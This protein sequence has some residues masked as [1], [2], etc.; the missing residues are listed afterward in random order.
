MSNY[1]Q[2]KEKESENTKD[3]STKQLV[4]YINAHRVILFFYSNFFCWTFSMGALLLVPF[5]LL[6]NP[7]GYLITVVFHLISW[8]FHL[9]GYIKEHATDDKNELIITIDALKQIRSERK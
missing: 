8:E 3:F 5:F 7:I 2:I 1:N 4:M 6:N 9:K